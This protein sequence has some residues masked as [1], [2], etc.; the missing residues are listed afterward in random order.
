MCGSIIEPS[1]TREN[2]N[3][4]ERHFDESNTKCID[5]FEHFD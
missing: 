1:E 2:V 4:G 3:E 5:I